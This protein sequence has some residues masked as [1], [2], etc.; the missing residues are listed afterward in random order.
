MATLLVTAN[1]FWAAG[2]LV[3]RPAVHQ[4]QELP[5]LAQAQQKGFETRHREGVASAVKVPRKVL[6]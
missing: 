2:D 4:F 5:D 1:E 6:P 3:L